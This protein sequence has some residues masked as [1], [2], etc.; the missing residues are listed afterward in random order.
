MAFKV[1]SGKKDEG[2]ITLTRGI[3]PDAL[4]HA[5]D[6]L[7]YLD[8]TKGMKVPRSAV[9]KLAREV[10]ASVARKRRKCVAS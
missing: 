5:L 7:R 10:N 6:H 2:V 3:E 1:T 8:L 9:D 4:Q